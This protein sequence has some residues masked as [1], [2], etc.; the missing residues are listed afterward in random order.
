[1]TASCAPSR[2]AN[3]TSSCGS[4]AAAANGVSG[5]GDNEE[6]SASDME[7]QLQV[8]L[9]RAKIAEEAFEKLKLENSQNVTGKIQELQPLR[10]QQWFNNRASLISHILIPRVADCSEIN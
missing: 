1:M 7:Q 4:R 2:C 3:C 10:S 5:N 9:Q 8:A 6:A